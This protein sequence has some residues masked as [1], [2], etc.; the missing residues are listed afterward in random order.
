V[1]PPGALFRCAQE[2]AAR[3]LF[4][5]HG[6]RGRRFGNATIVSTSAALSAR[7]SR[8]IMQLNGRCDS[9]TALTAR[10]SGETA[11]RIGGHLRP[12]SFWLNSSARLDQVDVSFARMMRAR[13]LDPRSQPKARAEMA[14]V[15]AARNGREPI[16]LPIEW[17]ML[18]GERECVGLM[19]TEAGRAGVA[20]SRNNGTGPIKTVGCPDRGR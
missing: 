12:T 3:P 14:D 10:R 2:I 15:H 7:R 8:R 19:S 13:P 20:D 9:V 4:E 16:A 11:R 5:R 1:P 17:L 6:R 18:S